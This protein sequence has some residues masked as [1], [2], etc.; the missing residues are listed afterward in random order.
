M[1]T[2]ETKAALIAKLQDDSV[3][4]LL[5]FKADD[6]GRHYRLNTIRDCIECLYDDGR[7]QLGIK[8]STVSLPAC[9]LPK[10]LSV[11]KTKNNDVYW[12]Y[13]AL[14]SESDRNQW[15]DYLNSVLGCIGE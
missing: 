4:L 12:V 9:E 15:A 13:L 6:N 7:N 11:V 5:T 1:M 8:P 2:P 14:E 10:L 3:E